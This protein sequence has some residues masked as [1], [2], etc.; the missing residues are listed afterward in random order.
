MTFQVG[1]QLGKHKNHGGAGRL[2]KEQQEE[3]AG[4]IPDSIAEW[5]YILKKDATSI[6]WHK[7]KADT[8][9]KLLNKFVGEKIDM[10]EDHGIS[11]GFAKLLADIA[12]GVSGKSLP[13]APGTADNSKENGV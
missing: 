1:N 7:L 4:L 12:A 2:T 13:V 5:R 8:A 10:K 3:L 9:G 6:D 11:D